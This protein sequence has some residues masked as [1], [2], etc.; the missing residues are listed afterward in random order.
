[1]PDELISADKL[2]TLRLVTNSSVPNSKLRKVLIRHGGD[3]NAAAS[4]LIFDGVPPSESASASASAPEPAFASTPAAVSTPIP[5]SGPRSG[6]TSSPGSNVN[7]APTNGLNNSTT[8]DCSSATQQVRRIA[9]RQFYLDHRN[10]AVHHVGPNKAAIDQ[11]IA[12]AWKKMGS[13]GRKTYIA[14]FTQR[15]HETRSGDTVQ[16]KTEIHDTGQPAATVAAMAESIQIEQINAE[17]P[18]TPAKTVDPLNDINVS[19]DEEPPQI[20][21]G[22][23]EQSQS[24]YPD[25]HSA[26]AICPPDS[27]IC[28]TLP[29]R[30]LSANS[31]KMNAHE[32]PLTPVDSRNK[33]ETNSELERMV[34]YNGQ[35]PSEPSE[36]PTIVNK[37]PTVTVPSV[38]HEGS[39]DAEIHPSGLTGNDD[40]T[41]LPSG[42]LTTEAE[43]NNSKNI[44]WPRKIT[45][46]L[47]Q[48]VMLISGKNKI[49]V[50]DD[51][52][53][54]A[55]QPVLIPTRGRRKRGSQPSTASVAPRIVRFSK[56]GRELGRLATDIGYALA[57]A[58]QSGYVYGSCKVVSAPKVS[59]MMAEVILDISIYIM[60]DAFSCDVEEDKFEGGFEDDVADS[61]DGAA[62][63]KGVDTR[64]MNVVH[65]LS[66]MKLCEPPENPTFAIQPDEN[67]ADA[68]AVT[69]ENAEAYYRTV[70][71]IDENAANAFESPKYLSCTLREYQRVGVSWMVS[72]EKHGNLSKMGSGPTSDFVINPLWKKRQFPDGGTFYMNSSTG[73]LSLKP[74][75]GTAGGPYGGILADEMG[76]GKT[77]QCIAC[78]LHDL[79]EQKSS[80][81]DH[82]K[83][84]MTKTS[85]VAKH[86]EE[87]FED[88]KSE[89]NYLG[90]DDP[91]FPT[92]H[93]V[94][95]VTMDDNSQR[96]YTPVPVREEE[97][98]TDFT[99]P[100]NAD[101]VHEREPERD[102]IEPETIKGIFVCPAPKLRSRKS[103]KASQKVVSG[104]RREQEKIGKESGQSD[105]DNSDEDWHDSTSESDECDDEGGGDRVGTVDL[106]NVEDDEDFIKPVKRRR[107]LKS[108]KG[109]NG[110][111]TKGLQK[112]AAKVLMSAL[113]DKGSGKGGTLI[114]CP[115]SLVT[116]WM[117]ELNTHVVPNFIRAVAHYGHARGQSYSICTNAVDIVVTTYGTLA[118][119]FA[120][121]ESKMNTGGPV[122]QLK[123]RRVILDEAHTIKSRLT[124]W[125]KAAYRV[126]AER[127]WCVTGTVIHNHVNDVFSL[128]HFLQVKPWSSWAF[129]N[130]GVVSNL[131]SKNVASQKTAMCL[132]RDIISSIT[133]RR[134]KSTKDSGG[135][136]IIQLTKK[137]VDLVVLTPSVEERDFY[138]ALHKRTKLKFDAFVAQGK[139]LNNYASVLELLLRLR[140]ACD[141]P[142][143]VFAAAPSKDAQ[144]LKDKDK[145]Y[146]A[147]VE[148]GSSTQFV[149]NVLNTAE[150]GELSK[151]QQCPLCL[152]IIE[153]AVAPRE[154]GH[155][156][157]RACLMAAVQRSR[158]CPICRATISSDSITT[159][160]RSGRF[161]IDLDQKWRS[162]AKIEELLREVIE[163]K[164]RRK[165]NG[166][167][168]GKSVIFSQFTSMLD[169]VQHALKKSGFIT[170]RIDGSVAQAQRATILDRFDN[171]DEMDQ[172]AANI[173]LVSLRAGGVG[174][175]LVSASH[176]I[177]LDIHWN[178]QVD[179]QAQDRIHRHGQT[180]DVV[181]RRYVIKDSVE[182]R[183]LQVQ[184]RKQDIAD[185]ALG[186]ATEDDKKQAR[187]SEL[188]LLFGG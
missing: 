133:L 188:K 137:N 48:G 106:V 181:I 101:S 6:I 14:K 55:P 96:H 70:E 89:R 114:V 9:W 56:A 111:T 166:T 159:L 43:E 58:L 98:H 130:R 149:E 164:E 93:N 141:H 34:L 52:I 41:V 24:S 71:A 97:P 57:P 85:K 129:W 171:E 120:D 20:V 108:T 31:M 54:E 119:E 73:A 151:T 178:P 64:R 53:L 80:R 122:F 72:R 104:E 13:V 156:A 185:G 184:A 95:D 67:S 22:V 155:P 35:R 30:S 183:L 87:G 174:L 100:G 32:T 128:L 138:S 103:V 12:S 172:G 42:R 74:P 161:S 102:S 143:L 17:S 66:T 125:A 25:D 38:T 84:N 176:A 180:R 168:I 7:R 27:A 46:R 132:V 40:V 18:V 153:D 163:R 75:P 23:V 118:S 105:S 59:R 8:P 86:D 69:E 139:V 115:T 187:L 170:M 4:T 29:V 51:L 158:K 107:G 68:G 113:T 65:L 91:R 36:L 16:I 50:G 78:I 124:R 177:L 19:R 160:P 10:E 1:M 39:A 131:E 82:L 165:T 90:H 142:Y 47:C 37:S 186:V 169:L 83:R 179:A 15:D 121:D 117:N 3:V 146:R 11:Y 94:E 5:A 63:V 2:D 152:D 110:S 33:R 182:E 21:N 62:V 154:C 77:V 173:L 81:L 44:E 88:N 92:E 157:C 60:K 116:Q 126:K 123:W 135:K 175:N 167:G 148:G 61:T 49:S 26:V 136:P 147:F 144:L 28:S 162:S 109:K 140:Q 45:T 127:R 145:L 134:K 150:S 112:S 99:E 79:E 76:L